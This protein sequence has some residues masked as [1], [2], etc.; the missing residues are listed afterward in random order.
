MRFSSREKRWLRVH[1][2]EKCGIPGGMA[3][4]DPSLLRQILGSLRDIEGAGNC[5]IHE[6]CCPFLGIFW[7]GFSRAEATPAFPVASRENGWS[8]KL[9]PSV[10]FFL[11]SPEVYLGMRIPQFPLPWKS[12]QNTGK[13]PQTS[14]CG[15]FLLLIPSE[16]GGKG[17]G[18]ALEW[19]VLLE[20]VFDPS[21]NHPGG[22]GA[23]WL[24]ESPGF[25]EPGMEGAE[26]SLLDKE[27][28]TSRILMGILFSPCSRLSTTSLDSR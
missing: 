27:E 7:R 15:L 3:W 20:E 9:N 23:S 21:R 16:P 25:L 10:P 22:F 17:L 5:Q 11:P 28:L 8:G 4:M 1:L 26:V 12:R 19:D 24:D 6:E 2:M 14:P 13:R 18:K